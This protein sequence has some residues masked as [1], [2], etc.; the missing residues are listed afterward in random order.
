[1]SLP[2]DA[3]S[4]GAPPTTAPTAKSSVGR[5][6]ELAE[7]GLMSAALLHELRQPLFALKAHIHLLQAQG[8]SEVAALQTPLSHLEDLVSFY[9]TFGRPA[10]PPLP[11][12]LNAEVRAGLVVLAHQATRRRIALDLDLAPGVL[13]VSARPVAVRQVLVNL[14]LNACDAVEGRSSPR[15]SVLTRT[16]GGAHQLIVDDNGPGIDPDIA[17]HAFEAW[18]T[19]KGDRGSGLGLHLT[20]VLVDEAGGTVA[21]G[22]SEAGGARVTVSLPGI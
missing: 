2:D 8:L 13:G 22:R 4:P 6:E 16:V 18:V 15:I 17:E 21:L 11:L 12:D 19:T 14:V 10:A 5:A 3:D 9:G 20:K 1:M 7:L